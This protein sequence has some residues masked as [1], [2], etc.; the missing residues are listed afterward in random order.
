ML[1]GAKLRTDAV[2]SA[3]E[4]VHKNRERFADRISSDGILTGSSTSGKLSWKNEQ[5][6]T[7]RELEQAEIEAA[8]A[9]LD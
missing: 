3:P 7:L 1:A 5:G 8:T 2:Q 4:S 9:A 6:I